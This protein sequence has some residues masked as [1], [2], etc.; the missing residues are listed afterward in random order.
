MLKHSFQYDL[1][2]G[3]QILE[4]QFTIFQPGPWLSLAHELEMV[5]K[6]E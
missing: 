4:L 3:V 6:T 5:L 1:L 2:S